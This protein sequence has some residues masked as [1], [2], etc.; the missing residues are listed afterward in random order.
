MNFHHSPYNIIP[1]KG[2]Q[3]NYTLREFVVLKCCSME[4]IDIALDSGQAS[5]VDHQTWD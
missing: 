4:R 3:A 2:S 5:F 1:L